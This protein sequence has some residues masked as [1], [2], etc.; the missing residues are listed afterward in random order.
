MV[1]SELTDWSERAVNVEGRRP[2]LIICEGML[3]ARSEGF[4]S[5]GD[6]V[7]RAALHMAAKEYK[8]YH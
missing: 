7:G 1:E 2:D 4:C 6:L 8:K 5:S 3:K